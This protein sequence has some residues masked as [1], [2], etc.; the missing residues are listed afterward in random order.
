MLAGSAWLWLQGG[1]A[2]L[3][4][5]GVYLVFTGKLVPRSTLKDLRQDRDDRVAEARAETTVWR[6]AYESS[7][8]AN[9]ALAIQLN[10]MLEVGHTA[11]RVLQ[12][13]PGPPKPPDPNPAKGQ[14]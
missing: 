6:E 9:E 13:L 8:R 3:V 7:K 10:Q 12:S 5:L 2:T 11:N 4:A 14:P 1:F